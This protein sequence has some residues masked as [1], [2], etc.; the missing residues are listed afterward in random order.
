MV[1]VFGDDKSNYD[2]HGGYSMMMIRMMIRI[3]INY[4]YVQD[5]DH[6]KD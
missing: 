4:D 6:H 2:N 3:M 5:D 1:I